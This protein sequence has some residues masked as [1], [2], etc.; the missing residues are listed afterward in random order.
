MDSPWKCADSVVIGS[1]RLLVCV[2]GGAVGMLSQT[3]IYLWCSKLQAR[4]WSQQRTGRKEP[5]LLAS[6]G[7]AAWSING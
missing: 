1:Y 5:D 6:R 4:Q 2:T 7:Y 3:G